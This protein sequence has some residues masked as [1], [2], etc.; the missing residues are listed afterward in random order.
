MLFDGHSDVVYA[1]NRERQRGGQDVFRRRYLQPFR[2]GQ[3]EGGI[4]VLWSN[5]EVHIPASV[6]IQQQMQTL[7]AELEQAG[8]VLMMLRS[9]EDIRLAT[10]RNS[11]YFLLGVE[12]LDGCVQSETVIDWLYE[13][14]VRHVGLT[15]N[16]A[17]GFAGGVYADGGLTEPGR[18]AVQRI[19]QKN[20]LMD[21][22]HLNDRS[23]R[24]VLL[25]ADGP[26]IA[27]H[28][29]S[30]RLCD[31]PRNLTDEQIRAI[32]ETDGV[33]GINSHPPFLHACEEKQDLQHLADHVIHIAE[34][35]GTEH[36]GFG[37]DLNYWEEDADA[38]GL[39]EL[40]HYGQ[41]QQ[42]L[43]LLKQRGFAE[44]ELQQIC[45]DNFLRLVKRSLA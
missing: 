13:Q 29:N 7:H 6:Q 11:I 39:P 26:I 45:R 31:V 18:K 3:V 20:M 34:L 21:V 42:F 1:L 5:P 33:I 37:L 30:R 25:L 9:P 12:G 24:D 28:S 10:N 8:D 35:A 23:L 38:A 4:F 43:A 19:Q 16:E 17:N 32:A 44:K 22:S 27:S 15:W 14:G 41:T 40:K 36:V 2:Q